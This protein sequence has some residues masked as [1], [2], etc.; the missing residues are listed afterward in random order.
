MRT[1]FDSQYRE[2]KELADAALVRA[3]DL[4]VGLEIKFGASDSLSVKVR[5]GTLDELRQNAPFGVSLRVFK[6]QRS[7]SAASSHVDRESVL[8]LLARAA[9]NVTLVDE[10]AANGL[11]DQ[12]LLYQG[13]EVLDV[14]DADIAGLTVDKALA[15]AKTAEAAAFA[16]DPRITN[17]S[18][19][20]VGV[21][22]GV[23]AIFNSLGLAAF[24]P[25]TSVSLSV[26]PVAEDDRGEKY[27]DGWWDASRYVADLDAPDAIGKVAGKRC[28][29]LIGAEKV[30][31][32]RYPVVFAPETAKDL[33][34]LLFGCVSGTA[35]YKKNTFL[36]DTEG[37]PIA[38]DLVTVVDDPLRARGLG[39][40][41]FDAEG[42][43]TSR[44]TLVDKGTLKFYPCSTFSARRLD[45]T[46][47]G[48]SGGGSSVTSHNLY[49]ESGTTPPE[50]IMAGIKEGLYVTAFIGFSFN[51]ATG[52]FSRGVRGFWVKDGKL[53][54]PV[55][56]TTVSGNLGQMFKDIVAVGNDLQFRFGTDAPTIKIKEMTVSGA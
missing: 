21:N 22:S 7:V 45:R 34:D 39:S 55:Q 26:S 51:Q 52:D 43:A 25:R 31:T 42:V 5:K 4:G 15:M 48:H 23:T 33:V 54:K 40:T 29:A 46:S 27:S 11:P 12:A 13:K 30:K 2:W 20:S 3:N 28:V 1:N 41:P 37:K 16:V 56:E 24:Q 14:F 8:E 18:G 35:I 32:G 17:S 6:G 44:Q 50:E 49:L 9:D 53:G 10:D 19:A 38:S 47:T 36:A